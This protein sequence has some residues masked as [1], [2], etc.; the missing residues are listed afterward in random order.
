MMRSTTL[1]AGVAGLFLAVGSAHAEAFTLTSTDI[2]EGQPLSDAQLSDSFGCS[3][4]NTSP[5]LSWSNP[6]EGTKSFVVTAYDPDAPTGSGWW[7]WVV[8]NIPADV[9]SL[10]TGAGN[11][12]SLPEGAIQ[13]RT[14]LGTPGFLGACPPPGEEHRYIFT[15]TALDVEHL[16]LDAEASPALVGF[17]AHSQSLGAATITATYGH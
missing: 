5:E 7:H 12:G 10:S 6:P 4:G 13:S 3:G 1:L 16:D 11:G 9:M 2:A 14:D 15:V 17:M 8:F